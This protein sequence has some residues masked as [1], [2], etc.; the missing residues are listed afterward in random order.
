M[1]S[2]DEKD[3]LIRNR[4]IVAFVRI[5]QKGNVL[6]EREVITWVTYIVDDWI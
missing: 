1:T 6:A 3:R 4:I 2:I 5:A